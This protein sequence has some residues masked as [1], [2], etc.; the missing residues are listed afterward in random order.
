MCCRRILSFTRKDR[1]FIINFAPLWCLV[2]QHRTWQKECRKCWDKLV[3]GDYDWAYLAMHLWPERVVP[4]CAKDRS[5]AI[6]HGLEHVFWEENDDGKWQPH[7]MPQQEIDQLIAE[8]TSAAV[9]DALKGLLETPAP[10]MGRRRSSA[11]TKTRRKRTGPRSGTSSTNA[12][13]SSRSATPDAAVL[14]TV[15][16]AIAASNGGAGKDDVLSST[17][18]TDGQWNVAI[19]ALL[20]DGAVIKTGGG[21]G[22][23]YHPMTEN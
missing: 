20:A 17:G 4:K 10:V 19:K 21:R 8:R 9:K 13:G 6:A 5:L 22:T 2:P 23:R 3:A 16:K 7:K 11:R 18:L 12:P 1:G 15:K 14:D